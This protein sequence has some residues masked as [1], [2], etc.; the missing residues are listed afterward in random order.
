MYIDLLNHNITVYVY[1]TNIDIV[2]HEINNWFLEILDFKN[3]D[4]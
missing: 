2:Q 1:H 4:L 3:D